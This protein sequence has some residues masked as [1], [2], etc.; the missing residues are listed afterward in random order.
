MD[1]D[2]NTSLSIEIQQKFEFYF[3][4]LIFTLLALAVQSGEFGSNPYSDISEIVGWLFLLISG[5]FGLS[6]LEWLPV[7]YKIHAKIGSFEKDIKDCNEMLNNG[8]TVARMGTDNRPYDIESII[9][10]RKNSITTIEPKVKEIEDKT[11]SKYNYQKLFFLLG[12]V[13]LILSRSL[14]PIINIANAFLC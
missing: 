4:A 7:A 6:R 9:E 2:P 10:N 8:H 14:E 11:L 5:L 3:I 13:A 1:I 12:L